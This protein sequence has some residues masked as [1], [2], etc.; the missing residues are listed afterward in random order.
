MLGVLNTQIVEIAGF[1]VTLL[2]LIIVGVVVF[3]I[4]KR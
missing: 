2:M 3:F 1:K 4:W